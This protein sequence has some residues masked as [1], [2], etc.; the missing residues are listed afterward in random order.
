MRKVRKLTSFFGIFRPFWHFDLVNN[1]HLSFKSLLIHTPFRDSTYRVNTSVQFWYSSENIAKILVDPCSNCHRSLE[2]LACW[3]NNVYWWS[4]EGRNW[5]I[6]NVYSPQTF[7]N[8][9]YIA[10]NDEKKAFWKL[11]A[12]EMLLR[13]GTRAARVRV[14]YV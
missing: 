9:S 10:V 1:L 14:T 8:N 5:Q 4:V 12:S 11:S 6:L 13:W 7:E 2:S 3:R